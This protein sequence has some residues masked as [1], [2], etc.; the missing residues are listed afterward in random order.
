MEDQFASVP[1]EALARLRSALG[2]EHVR[3]DREAITTHTRDTSLWQR[4]PA[5]IAYPADTRQVAETV[6]VAADF[7]LEVWPFSQ[8]KNW[9]YGATMAFRR[10]AVIVVLERMNRIVEVNEALAYAVIEPGVTQ[11]QLREHLIHHGLKLWTDCT[12]STPDASVIGNALERGVGY[13]PYWDHFGHLCGLEVVLADGSV[14][15]TGGGAP[16]S[17]TAHIYRWGTGPF[18][19]GLF[20]QSNL[21]IVTRAGVWLMP[22]PEAFECFVCEVA[23]A[24]DQPAVTDA[25][26]GLALR[27]LLPA[28]VH[29]VNDILALAQMIQYPYHLTAGAGRLPVDVRAQ[30][31]RQY[32]V[33]PWTVIG[34]LYG[35]SAQVG[36]ARRA[37]SDAL[38]PFGKLTFF[39]AR[40]MALLSGLLQFWRGVEGV[41][42]ITPVLT[43]LT[44]SSLQRLGVLPHLYSILQ[45]I[46]GDFI[47]R[48]AYFKMPWRP[49]RDV[50]PARDGAGLTWLAVVSPLTGR[51]TQELLDLAAPVFEKHGLDL[52]IAFIMVNARS[53]L[54]LI[55]IFFNRHSDRECQASELVYAELADLTEAAGYTQYRTSVGYSDRILAGAPAFHRMVDQLKGALDPGGVIAPGRYGIGLPADEGSGAAGS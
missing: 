5:V 49:D 37:V 50:D 18:I 52:S 21:G 45:G 19:E 28:N 30:L 34:G 25:I 48:F 32:R 33:T 46:P 29:V 4:V 13:T 12:D 3:T 23:D 47:V 55:E 38:R 27:R 40:K 39:N 17:L 41:P 11:R 16:G 15:Q 24:D 9:G 7:G 10:G 20:S 36:V 6:R 14:V 54:C 53:T 43:R 8:G 22:E 35:T 26:R 31:Q 51:H 44:G 1:A 2:A 42:G